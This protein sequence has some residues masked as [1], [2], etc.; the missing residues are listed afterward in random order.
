MVRFPTVL[1]AGGEHQM[2]VLE[3]LGLAQSEHGSRNNRMR[4]L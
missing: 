2:P 4:A 3:A 1:A